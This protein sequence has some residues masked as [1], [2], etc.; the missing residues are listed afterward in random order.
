MVARA[1]PF[2]QFPPGMT[3]SSVNLSVPV[4]FSLR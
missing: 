3:Q 4:R 1:S 2:P